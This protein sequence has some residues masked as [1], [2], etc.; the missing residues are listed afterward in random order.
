[1]ANIAWAFAKLG[2]YDS[3]LMT[4][5]GARIA[6]AGAL[7]EFSAQAVANAAWAFATLDIRD[8]EV[9]AA[10]TA[11]ALRDGALAEF[12][13]Q[14]VA[15]LAWAFARLGVQDGPVMTA[16]AARILQEESLAKVFVGGGGDGG[17]RRWCAGG[18]RGGAE[19]AL[20]RP[21]SRGTLGKGGGGRLRT[22]VWGQQKQSND[23]HNQHILNTPIIGRR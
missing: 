21:W 10:I 5:I 13:A 18:G 9:M 17:A 15:N 16:L 23:P 19:A 22:E 4:A 2:V 7:A 6:R 8:P 14:E 12:K 3:A 1:M 20:P 11:R